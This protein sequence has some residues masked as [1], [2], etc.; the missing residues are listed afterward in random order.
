VRGEGGGFTRPG[1]DAYVRGV[2]PTAALAGSPVRLTAV[3]TAAALLLTAATVLLPSLPLAVE[4]PELH[5]VLETGEGLVALLVA[6]LLYGRYLRNS[7]ARALLVACAL[8][9]LAMANLLF[10]APSDALVPGRGITPWAALGVRF[11]GIALLTAASFLSPRRTV[12]PRRARRGLLACVGL[13][14]VLGGLVAAYGGRLPAA[15]DPAL[16]LGDLRSPVVGGHPLALAAQAVSGL[17]YLLAAGAFTRQAVRERDEL[18]R[19][20]GAGCALAAVARLNY[21]LFPSLYTDFVSVGDVLR[22]LFYAF[23][24]VGALR[25][26]RSYWAA[27]SYTAV[28]EDRRRLARDLH[29]GLT[30]ELTYLWSQTRLLQR[31]PGD[32][33]VVDRIDGAAARAIDEARTAIAALSRTTTGAFAD[34]LRESVDGLAGRYGAEATVVADQ[35]VELSPEQGDAVLRIV[36]EAFRNGVRHGGASCVRV[37]LT[38]PPLTLRVRDDGRGFDGAPETRTGGGFGLT[39]MRERAEGLGAVF[40]LQSAVGAGTTVE[41]RWP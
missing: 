11:V 20:L 1:R 5:V 29:D 19:W 40:R 33:Q 10:G 2:P 41:V 31:S 4:A 28:L 34:V 7:R 32:V 16:D 23:L 18:L 22:L 27:V 36:A 39:S 15:V 30:Q 12:E 35:G 17:L 38:C 24:L 26:L 14:V 9:V 3:S 8:G 13:V 25:E 21:L 6:Y 37:E